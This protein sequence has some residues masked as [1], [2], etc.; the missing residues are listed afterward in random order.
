M[1]YLSFCFSCFFC[2]MIRRSPRATRTDTLLP[3]T[4]LFLSLGEGVQ[5]LGQ[6]GLPAPAGGEDQLAGH[7]VAGGVVEVLGEG[8]QHVLGGGGVVPEPGDRKSTRLNSC[9]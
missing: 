3:Y 9:H 4:T 7:H 1:L 2:L 8:A 6:A 5:R